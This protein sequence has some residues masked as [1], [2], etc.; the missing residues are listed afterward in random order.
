MAFPAEIKGRVTESYKPYRLKWDMPYPHLHLVRFGLFDTRITVG[1]KFRGLVFILAS[2]DAMSCGKVRSPVTSYPAY[3]PVT[4]YHLFESLI[5]HL[6]V[7]GD[8]PTGDRDRNHG[9]IHVLL[10]M[11]GEG[12]ILV[13]DNTQS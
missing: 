10:H 13:L 5:I 1:N 3:S 8:E 12:E 11:P 7:G 2:N 4:R 9:L 6:S